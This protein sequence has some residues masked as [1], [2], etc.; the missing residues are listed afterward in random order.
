MTDLFN[1]PSL[2]LNGILKPEAV[3]KLGEE[4]MPNFRE[5]V[6]P[7]G[8]MLTVPV[9]R[10]ESPCLPLDL[11]MSPKRTSP[12]VNQVPIS[13]LPQ[14][15]LTLHD[16]TMYQHQQHN[17]KEDQEEAFCFSL[18]P[19]QLQDRAQEYLMYSKPGSKR[20]L[21]VPVR[22]PDGVGMEY[23]SDREVLLG[24]YNDMMLQKEASPCK[25]TRHSVS[26]SS[27]AGGLVA[28]ET[29]NPE[30]CKDSYDEFL[31]SISCRVKIF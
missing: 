26:E 5:M 27:T 29:R 20:K 18:T 11:H 7:Q 31:S 23:V 6:K 21:K 8:M 19:Q 25:Q 30:T 16:S 12:E 13:S 17:T 2:T 28:E 3:R 9:I 14:P 15:Q 24:Y 4:L 10:P 22:I 1:D